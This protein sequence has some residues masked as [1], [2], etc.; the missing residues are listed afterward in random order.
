MSVRKLWPLLALVAVLLAA[1]FQLRNQGRSWWCSCGQPFLWAGDIWSL[2]NSQH[3]LDPYAFTHVLHGFVF[4]WLLS[5][6]LPRM[7]RLW[8]LS[9]AILLEA[10]WEVFENTEFTIQRYREATAAQGYYGDSVANSLADVATCGIGFLIVQRLGLSRSI[11][12]FAL[13]E[14]VLL[15]WIRDSLLMQ[16]MML[17][18]P[19]D[20]LKAWQVGY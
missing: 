10:L 13:T 8:Q 17:I 2:H 4:F 19:I 1:T 16:I 5:W 14:L 7:P 12:A 6:L 11:V 3:L 9:L 20:S 15:I 18:Y